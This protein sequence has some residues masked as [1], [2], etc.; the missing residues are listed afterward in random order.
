VSTLQ[1]RVLEALERKYVTRH[2]PLHPVVARLPEAARLH[3]LERTGAEDLVLDA[4]RLEASV[5]DVSAE[6]DGVADVARWLFSGHR[7][8]RP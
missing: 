4:R 5:G 7:G 1:F 3:L 6:V 2:G 8:Q